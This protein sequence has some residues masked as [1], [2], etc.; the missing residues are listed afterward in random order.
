M[1][2]QLKIGLS[3]V[4][5]T[6]GQNQVRIKNIIRNNSNL[7]PE[8][9]AI[10]ILGD[11]GFNYC[12]DKKD[13]WTKKKASEFGIHIYCVRGNHEQRPELVPSMTSMYDDE[14]K[15]S[16]F[17]EEKFP[18]IKYFKDGEIYEINGYKTL[19]IGGAYSVDKHYRLQMN[20]NWFPNEQLTK[21]EMEAIDFKMIGEKVDLVLSHTCPLSWQPTDLFLVSI[22]QELADNTMEK[23]FDQLKD[24]FTWNV[25]CFGHY[26]ADRIEKPHVEMYY[27]DY[28]DL[29]TLMKRWKDY[30]K[31]SNLDW[32]LSIG[33]NF[34]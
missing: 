25:W 5:D 4:S 31:T 23:W 17:Y 12:L 32:W 2:Q 10:I 11:V 28:D 29:N 15:G 27:T 6:H 30:D 13:Y 18:L 7:I 9:T 21:D 34:Q 8:E 19:V 1:W 14:V 24:H 20:M 26:H 22:N 16:V 33:S 3:L